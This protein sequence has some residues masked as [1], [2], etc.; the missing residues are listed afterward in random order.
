MKYFGESDPLCF[1]HGKNY[2]VLG[3]EDGYYRI[4]DE[5][6]EDYLYS[7]ELFDIVEI[8]E[9]ET[10]LCPVCGDFEFGR[11]DADDIC[12][13]CG[14]QNDI[15]QVF[16]PDEDCGMNPM[17]LNQARKAWRDK[18][19]VM[20]ISEGKRVQCIEKNGSKWTGSVDVYETAF[21]NEDA[22]QIGYSI[23]V[24]RDDGQ[25]V[26]VF[27]KDIECISVIDVDISHLDFRLIDAVSAGE[28]WA[29]DA[30]KPINVVEIYIDDVEIAEIFR[31]IEIPY[32]KAE[33]HPDLAGDYGHI[34]ADELYKDLIEATT[35]GSFSYELGVYPLCCESCGEPG[36]WSV[37][38]HVREDD[39]YVWWYGFAHEHRDWK[40]DLEF[41]FLKSEYTEAMSKLAQWKE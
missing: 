39:E 12:E 32:C 33:G 5:T 25:N 20:E 19:A 10:C 6:D 22:E 35:E 1:I 24:S 9:D 30:K 8:A 11:E 37:T 15:T 41:R 17:S 34:P 23:C 27:A 29:G 4:I 18:L 7:N 3:V 38:F 40:Y 14:W 2:V 16:N 21:E 36:C 26:I 31:K 13:I 28:E